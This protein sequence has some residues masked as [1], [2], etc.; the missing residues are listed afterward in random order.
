MSTKEEILELL[1]E[2]QGGYY[3]GEEIARRL[4]V[5]RAAVCKAVRNLR[6][7][8]Y[9]IDGVTR[10]GYSLSDGI[11][12][13]SIR[14]IRGRLRPELQTMEISVLPLAASTNAI[15]HERAGE[16]APQWSLL[17]AEEQSSGRGRNQRSFFSPKDT[18]V[19]MSLLL[20]PKNYTADQ[21]VR[22]TVMAAVAVCEAIEEISGEETAIKWVNDIFMRGKKVC[23][24]LTEGTVS[25]ENGRLDYAVLGIGINLYEP[26][27]G[28]PREL[29]P[30]AG[31]V[32]PKARKDGKTRLI[33]SFLNR[34]FE[35]YADPLSADYPTRYRNRSL[36][37]GRHVRL[38]SGG[39]ESE[40]LVK[41]IDDECRLQVEYPD[42]HEEACCSGEISLQLESKRK[43]TA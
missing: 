11:D 37:I 24:I 33:S 35:S 31:A 20:R 12:P 27:E 19:Y 16:G 15:L 23:G 42:G 18:G 5:S 41:G 13:L 6:N 2:R 3:S 9:A 29:R 7:E 39:R 22:I 38:I 10:R 14:G 30:V 43:R 17:L 4:S 36:V 40:V 32:F 28:F 8:G 21:A 1:T 26:K 25:I 34:F